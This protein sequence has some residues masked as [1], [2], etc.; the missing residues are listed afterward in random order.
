MPTNAKQFK[1]CQCTIQFSSRYCTFTFYTLHVGAIGSSNR[2]FKQITPYGTGKSDPSDTCCGTKKKL[3][4]RVL[5]FAMKNL[6]GTTAA[7]PTMTAA[8]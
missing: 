7:S 6:C 4:H 5:F 3:P 1:S 8:W 2:S